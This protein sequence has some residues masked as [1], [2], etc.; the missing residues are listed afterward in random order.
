MRIVQKLLLDIALPM[1]RPACTTCHFHSY[2]IVLNLL[3]QTAPC[4]R[5]YA[6]CLVLCDRCCSVSH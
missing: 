4:L 1:H 2:T 6:S 5:M 3:L